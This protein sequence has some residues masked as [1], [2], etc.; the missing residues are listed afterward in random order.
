M[1]KPVKFHFGGV[2]DEAGSSL[3]DQINASLLLEWKEIEL[4]TIDGEALA[5]IKEGK[6]KNICKRIKDAGLQTTVIASRIGN[7]E[8]PISYPFA[9][10]R[11]ELLCLIERMYSLGARYLRIMSYPNDGFHQEIWRMKVFERIYQLTQIA[12]REGVVLLHENCSGWGS[13]SASCTL[14]ML[15]QI[16]TP[17]LQVLFDIGNPVAY[18]Y[19]GLAYLHAVLPWV[20]HVHLKDASRSANGEVTFTYPGQGNA[21]VL[22]CVQ[23]LLE[24]GYSGLLSIEP[25]LHIIPHLHKTGT[26][27]QLRD[28]YVS[29]GRELIRLLETHTWK[30]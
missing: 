21:Q 2:G 25:H 10:E 12:E 9:L 14:Q 18:N 24:D 28:S 27:A 20:A 29:Y 1:R 6:F 8:R 7:W 17:A 26:P 3:N 19:D 5:D 22:A 15:R 11:K 4:R 16:N 13:Q 23:L 30:F